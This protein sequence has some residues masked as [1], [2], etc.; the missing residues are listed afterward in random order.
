MQTSELVHDV[1]KTQL[2]MDQWLNRKAKTVKLLLTVWQLCIWQW[3]IGYD[4]EITAN[5]N[6]KL[7]FIK[8]KIFVHQIMLSII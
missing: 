4:T 5:E 1:H 6:D 2:K 7:G 3:L 8:I